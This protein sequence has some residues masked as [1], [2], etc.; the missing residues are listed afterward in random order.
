MDVKFVAKLE[1][2]LTEEVIDTLE[3]AHFTEKDKSKNEQVTRK[4]TMDVFFDIKSVI[5]IEWAPESQ[6]VIKI[7]TWR[8]WPSSKNE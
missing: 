1:L 3:D 7:T 5:M 8:S 2:T 6:M 4:A